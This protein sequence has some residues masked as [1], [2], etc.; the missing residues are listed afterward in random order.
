MYRDPLAYFISFRT[1]GTWLH[2]DD[3]GSVDPRHN[4]YGTPFLPASPA[5]ERSDR[6]QLADEPVTLSDAH[7]GVVERTISEVCEHRRWLLRAVNVR[8]EHVHVVVTAGGP[9]EP[10]MTAFKA[11]CTRR[12][13]EHGLVR[14]DQRVW[15]LHGSTVYLFTEDRVVAACRYITD[16]Q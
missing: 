6:A 3:R 2:G 4:A 5:R 13:R 9:P 8:T 12:L 16:G 14:S 11:W 7:R 1:Y 15:S 10:V